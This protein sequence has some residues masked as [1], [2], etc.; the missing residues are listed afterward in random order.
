MADRPGAPKAGSLYTPEERQRRD[1]SPWTLVQG[2]LAPLQ[3]L[4]FAISLALILRYLVTGE[5][6]GAANASIVVKTL[7]LYTIMIT[8]SIW[9][10]VVF[11]QY[12]FARPFFWEDMV[13]MLV[14]ALH[15]AYLACLFGGLL[16][17]RGLML[18]ALAAYAS[19]VVNAAQFVLKLRA[20]RLA[21][22]PQP[23][24]LAGSPAGLE[25]SR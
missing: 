21:A 15:T 17:H 19:Y 6:L 2:I 16:D 20:A 14:L 25:A 10:K 23:K 12:L 13:S 7:V 1:S 5:G 9:E 18:L 4:V 3:F 24:R 11:G 8:G 22:P